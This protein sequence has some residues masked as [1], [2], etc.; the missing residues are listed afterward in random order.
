[1]NT[2]KLGSKDP[3]KNTSNEAK[4]IRRNIIENSILVNKIDQIE[5]ERMFNWKNIMDDT[6]SIRTSLD[7]TRLSTG[8]AFNSSKNSKNTKLNDMLQSQGKFFNWFYY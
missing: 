2:L 7:S 3:K 6:I 8:S 1:M 5:R 4:V